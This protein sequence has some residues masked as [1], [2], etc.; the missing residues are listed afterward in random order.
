MVDL[1]QQYDPDA[2]PNSFDQVPA[3][4]YEA[5]I[6]ESS[7]EPISKDKDIGDCLNL[8]WRV[9]AGDFAGRLFWQRL[10]LWWNGPEKNPGTVV[11]ISNAQFK[12]IRDATGVSMPSDST[13]LHNIPCFVTYGPQ[14][15]NPEYSEVK[16]VKPVPGA[17]TRQVA[18]G[19]G[20]ASS[21]PQQQA[22]GGAPWRRAG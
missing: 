8:C 11:K 18:S 6:I 3:G 17:P 22:N 2:E 20:R 5:E 10:N 1:V 21:P 19:G 9:V 4:T 12:D 16:S 7:K 15:N 14:K 13:E